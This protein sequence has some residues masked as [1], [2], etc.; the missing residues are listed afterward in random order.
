MRF[1]HHQDVVSLVIGFFEALSH[2]L[3]QP[4]SKDRNVRVWIDFGDLRLWRRRRQASSRLRFGAA[5]GPGVHI[6]PSSAR[7]W[8]VGTRPARLILVRSAWCV[9]R[10]PRKILLLWVLLRVEAWK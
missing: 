10:R 3:G 1:T 5:G 9:P 2:Q 8:C 6:R 4:V 7:W